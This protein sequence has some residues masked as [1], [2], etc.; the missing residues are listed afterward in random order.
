MRE[1]QSNQTKKQ[2]YCLKKKAVMLSSGRLSV[3]TLRF[4]PNNTCSLSLSK[5]S[6]PLP[7]ESSTPLIPF[8]ADKAC[9]HARA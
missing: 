7:N 3:R 2:D 1:N 4:L 6:I 9:H 5:L 8:K